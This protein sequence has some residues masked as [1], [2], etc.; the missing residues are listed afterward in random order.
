MPERASA[1]PE[2]DRFRSELEYIDP[3]RGHSAAQS[4]AD[5]S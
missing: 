2:A 5:C 4:K 1:K 3:I